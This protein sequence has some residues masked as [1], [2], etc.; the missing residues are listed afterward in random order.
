MSGIR[1]LSSDLI[2][3][4][5]RPYDPERPQYDCYRPA[6]SGSYMILDCWVCDKQG[7]VHPGY[8]V[9]PVPVHG[10]NIGPIVGNYD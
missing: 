10:R 8:N 4:A 1:Y 3:K 7:R 6:E 2:Y 5:K 9:S